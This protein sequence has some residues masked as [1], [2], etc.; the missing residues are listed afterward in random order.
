[1]VKVEQR[2]LGCIVGAAV[3]DALGMPTEYISDRQLH[4]RYGA[5]VTKFEDP[6]PNHPCGHLKAGQYTDDTQQVI[7]LAESLVSKRWF[8]LHDFG[9]KMGQWA[10]NC[11]TI[12]GYDRFSGGTSISASMEL[13]HGKDPQ[14]TG[15]PAPTCGSAMRIAPLGLFFYNNMDK[16][17]EAAYWASAVTH[18]HPA[19]IDSALLISHLVGYLVNDLP[20]GN[21]LKGATEV[22]HS[23]LRQ[24]VDYV[25]R[26]RD[27]SPRVIGSQIG[28]SQSSYET[29]PMA[30]HCFLHT[31]DDFEETVINAA[32][33]TPGDTDSIACIAGAISG[34]Y[35]GYESIPLKFTKGLE[36]HDELFELSRRLLEASNEA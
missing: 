19:A 6:S 10:N 25:I 21:A 4:N 13:F 1:M 16:L 20:L 35:N 24:N 9:Q 2:F 11:E 29:V 28:V 18:N 23:D 5:K 33:L 34:A 7:L 17:Q 32:N 12:P 14:K 15:K 22:L 8:D 30:L 26:N 31:P 3:G 36:D 27:K